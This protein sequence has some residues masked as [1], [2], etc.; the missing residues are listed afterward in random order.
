MASD[1]Y[2]EAWVEPGS[3]DQEMPKA[4]KDERRS[5]L[6]NKIEMGQLAAASE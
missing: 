3:S 1:K 2:N 6:L 5:I 4:E